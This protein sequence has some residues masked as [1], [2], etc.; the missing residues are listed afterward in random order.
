MITL[1]INMSGAP[2]RALQTGLK[3]A[4]WNITADGI[5]GAKT[6][7]A[8]REFQM[9]NALTVDGIVGAKTWDKILP[10]IHEMIGALCMLCIQEMEESPNY[11]KMLELMQY[12]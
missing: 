4:G 6:D 5:F 2:V 12:E 7:K 3:K 11:K 10:Y 1:K 9:K 8:V